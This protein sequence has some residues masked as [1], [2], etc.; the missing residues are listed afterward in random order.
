MSEQLTRYDEGKR[1]PKVELPGRLTR[2]SLSLP[3]DLTQED[4]RDV[5]RTLR[6]IDS[7]VMWWL[8]DWL[9]FGSEQKW[10][11][12]YDEALK[13][14][15][16]YGVARNAD[17]VAG[18]FEDLSRRR[19]KLSW[20]HH[21]AVASL[22]PAEAD[23][24][25]DEAIENEWSEKVLRKEVSDF[26]RRVTREQQQLEGECDQ[27]STKRP[28]RTPPSARAIGPRQK[29]PTSAATNPAVSEAIRAPDSSV[30]PHAPAYRS[31]EPD[32]PDPAPNPAVDAAP[33]LMDTIPAGQEVIGSPDEAHPVPTEA[34][35][36]IHGPAL[37]TMLGALVTH[38]KEQ[39]LS[40]KDLPQLLAAKPTFDDLDLRNLAKRL[41]D[42]ADVAKSVSPRRA[43][44]WRLAMLISLT[45]RCFRSA[46][47]SNAP[48]SG[49]WVARRNIRE[50]RCARHLRSPR[51]IT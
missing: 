13:L 49:Q 37:A 29:P 16:D 9:R 12:K 15:F 4:W 24:F 39:G 21:A 32:T 45:C 23:R 50:A 3:L 31:P 10:G 51:D 2:V 7:G 26:K 48:T 19:D 38:V 22:D 8:A 17:Y 20:S 43:K 18:K 30:A 42:F 25:L 47:P 27:H 1:K 28:T 44:R 33:S 46:S 41:K 34:E 40:G 5:G 6:K 11:E 14:G 36:R 35:D